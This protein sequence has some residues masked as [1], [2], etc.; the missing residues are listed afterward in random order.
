MESPLHRSVT[1][2]NTNAPARDGFLVHPPIFK[3]RGCGKAR[4][5]AA[6]EIRNIEGIRRRFAYDPSAE[7]PYDRVY[8]TGYYGPLARPN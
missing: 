1:F 5:R 6:S 7:R 8:A 4:S 3:A 2:M